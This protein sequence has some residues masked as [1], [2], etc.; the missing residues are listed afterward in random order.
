MQTW[1]M[2]FAANL[3]LPLMVIA[4]GWLLLRCYRPTAFTRVAAGLIVVGSR[5]SLSR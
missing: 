2:L 3:L 5:S 1:W 4:A